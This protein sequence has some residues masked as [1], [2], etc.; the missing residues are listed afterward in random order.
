MTVKSHR[1]QL[2]FQT[3]R[4]ALLGACALAALASATPAR[5]ADPG[6]VLA[7]AGGQASA[8]VLPAKT[9]EGSKHFVDSMTTRALGFLGDPA[10]THE[11]KANEF[12]LLLNDSFDM[13]TIGRFALGRYWK[14]LT[15]A[16]QK[17]YLS[18]FNKMIVNVYSKR[19]SDYNG[20]KL[21]VKSARQDGA[22]DVLV[23]SFIIP[24]DGPQVQVDWR[25]RYKDNRYRIV[26]VI[27]E[28]VSMSLTQRSDF[29]AVIQQG[30]GNVEALLSNLRGGGPSTRQN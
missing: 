2:S 9:I 25:V 4:A 26:D 1:I 27:V 17:E 12:K 18:L 10:V 29:S 30:G 22:R 16:Q 19:F 23:T 21:V 14:Q 7:T 20:Q 3:A 24:Q 11:K 6:V 8:A 13:D 28:G 15:P 5:A